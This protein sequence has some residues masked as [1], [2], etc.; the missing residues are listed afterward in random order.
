M[1]LKCAVITKYVNVS[2]L[3]VLFVENILCIKNSQDERECND[4]YNLL[5]IIW[6]DRYKK[7]IPIQLF[8]S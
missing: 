8:I 5:F 4:G 6:I 7:L 3:R 1:R 2:P